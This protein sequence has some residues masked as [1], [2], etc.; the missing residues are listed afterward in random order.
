MI[1]SVSRDNMGS[2]TIQPVSDKITD[3]YE[4]Y[5][6]KETGEECPNVSVFLQGHDDAEAFLNDLPKRK[7]DAIREGYLE[8]VRI[9]EHE[10]ATM[11]G[12]DANEIA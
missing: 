2:L 4:K 8:R 9:D 5:L 12:H 1:V 10:F 11:L 7:A 6:A 3:K